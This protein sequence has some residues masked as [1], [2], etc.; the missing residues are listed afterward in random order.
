MESFSLR[1]LFGVITGLL[2]VGFLIF[3][4]VS[5]SQLRHLAVHGPLYHQIVTGKD[6]VAD[7]LPPPA[8]VIEAD[9]VVHQLALMPDGSQKNQLMNQLAQLE[10]SFLER[11][12]FWVDQSLP[13]PIKRSIK[14]ELFP[15]GKDFFNAIHREL[16]AGFDTLSVDEKAQRLDA[17]QG[18]YEKHRVSVDHLVKLVSKNNEEI[19]ASAHEQISEGFYLL[20]TIF[21]LSVSAAIGIAFLAARKIYKHIGAEPQVAQ[22]VVNE[23]ANGNLRVAITAVQHQGSLM[24]GIQFMKNEITDIVKGIDT[25][26]REITQSIFHVAMTSKEIANATELQSQESS[27]VAAAT[28]ELKG[29]LSSVQAMT[30]QA[31]L[32]TKD[33]EDKAAEGLQS[34][35]QIIE[36]MD[37]AVERVEVS[38]DCV[39]SLAAAS[40]EINS[41]VSSIKTIADQ[42]NLL[43]LNAAIEAARAGEQGR[44]FA[45]V[46][47][48]VRTLAIKTGDA[49]SIIQK[50]VNDL[51]AKVQQTLNAMTEVSD[52]VKRTQSRA[53]TN[54]QSIQKMAVEARESSQF[55]LQIA[56]I[57]GEQ[58]TKISSLETKL[59]NLFNAMKTNF[60]TLDLIASISEALHRTVNSLQEKIRF[61]KFD[62]IKS[63]PDHPNEKRQHQR[64]RNSLFVTLYHGDQKTLARSRD[65]SM[66]GLSFVTRNKL[67]LNVGDSLRLDIK[68][69]SDAIDGYVAHPA[70][71]L[72]AKIIRQDYENSEHI[73]GVS[74]ENV[75]P[76]AKN[77]LEKAMAFYA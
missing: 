22:Q 45:V 42:T 56:S 1:K 50:I 55:S 8:Y 40:T 69:P 26:N 11:E 66:G 75:N 57:S 4:A 39:R 34:L 2:V 52:V 35:A 16:S 64:L 63:Q 25:I 12:A 18:Y 67:M 41:I 58:I 51:N 15:S 33:V 29:I 17:I 37:A 7:I 5:F 21:I 28:S 48:E 70:I 77:A 68:P 20:M 71:S 72:S 59:N 54:G 62:P 27:A 10:K 24:S 60:S 30:E 31:R 9:L 14:N 76:E 74:F 36:E 19:E 49:T 23:L 32:K 43:A 6:L 13:E 53:Q 73:Y 44:G 38:E 3:G 65:F 46:A 61:F 47:D